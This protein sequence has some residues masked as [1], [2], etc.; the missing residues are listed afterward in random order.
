[1]SDYENIILPCGICGQKIDRLYIGLPDGG[2]T[3]PEH[4]FKFCECPV[5]QDCLVRWEH[6]LGFS[7]ANFHDFSQLLRDNILR[8]HILIQTDSWVL[9]T[10]RRGPHITPNMKKDYADLT[11][12]LAEL[13]VD[14][15]NPLF[16]SVLLR[17][18]PFRL[19]C[20]WDQWTSYIGGG[21]RRKYIDQI[22]VAIDVIVAE[23]RTFAS[24]TEALDNLLHRQN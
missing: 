10:G 18:W 3:L 1:M 17:D 9:S 24:T 15:V 16:V 4:L 21:Y 11:L 7:N 13:Q 8:G 19:Y 20:L 5:H 2:R 6:R 23:V 22:L 14:T 12:Q